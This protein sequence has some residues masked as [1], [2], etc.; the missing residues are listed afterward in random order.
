ML[1]NGPAAATAFLGIA[2]GATCAPLNPAYR[3]EEFVFYLEDLCA[4]AVVLEAGSD[5]AAREAAARLGIRVI[6]VETEPRGPAGRLVWRGTEAA[7][8]SV[9]FAQPDDVALVLHTSGTTARPKIV[10]L[11]HANLTASAGHI[12]EALGLGPEDRCL[13]VMPLFHIHGLVAAVLAT[14]AAGGTVAC[15]PGFEA[16]RFFEWLEEF[17]PTWY[18][19]VPTMHQAVLAQAERRPEAARRAG[20]RFLRSSSSALAPQVMQRLEEAFGAPVIESYGMTEAA[21]QMTS[22]P[23]PPGVRKPGSVGLPAG[24][25]VA[26]MDEAGNLLPA[27]RTGE[28][29]IRGPNVT[30]GYENNP[31]ANA[32]AFTNGWFRTGDQGYF[33]ED[34]YLFLTGRIKEIINRG[35][36]KISPREVDEVLLEHPAVAQ[37]VAFAV[38]DERLGEDVAAAVVLRP[39]ERA[40]ELEL[41][42]FAARKLVDFKVP[43]RI[44]LVDEMPKGP[45]GKIQRIGLAEKL[46]LT[47]G[48]REAERG[49]VRP[50][51]E[52]EERLC[53]MW[54]ELLDVD[55]V[56]V[57][58]DFFGLGGDSVTA[59]RLFVRIEE[60][61]GAKLPLATLFEAPTVQ[62]LAERLREG[63]LEAR[64]PALAALRRG[65]KR[66]PVFL[67]H[68]HWGNVL[69]YRELAQRLGPEQPVYALQSV[70]LD[71]SAPLETVEAMAA[72]YIE[73]IRRVQPLGP[74]I[75]GG[76]CV[77]AYIAL[78][79]AC[80]LEW[81]GKPVLFVAS[82]G[83]DGTWR[84]LES[85]VDSLRYHWANIRARKGLA[86]AGYLWERVCYRLDAALGVVAAAMETAFRKKGRAAPRWVRARRLHA[87]H[88][89]ANRRYRPGR[90]SGRVVVFQG[91][92][93]AHLDPRMF[94]SR[95]AREVEVRRVPGSA[96]GM[97]RPP[98]V[99]RLAKEFQEVLDRY[100]AS[101]RREGMQV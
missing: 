25:E 33:D 8:G 31:E 96:E 44:V 7:G 48:R 36:E 27:G 13:N 88:L 101:R 61:F 80:R 87:A 72:R 91:E 12:R 65:G 17:R 5:S 14:M 22:N 93:E 81:E 64:W 1:P 3:I 95:V 57:E 39:G 63:R 45:T 82:L 78:E 79:M 62:G 50:E 30:A 46:G 11:T 10:P 60:E 20:L 55:R 76:Y 29:V 75:L 43:R 67:V 71:G 69:F 85:A 6:E 15:T 89:R 9:E 83:A 18:T 16:R 98:A 21:H 40:T 70:G 100:A 90:F 19:A 97:F 35:G 2:A 38:P 94:W 66:T 68:G 49:Y 53:A 23:L 92:E 54:A 26:V 51:T 41:Q 32:R 37:A 84:T 52:E 99:E 86:K 77:G 73:E 47:G 58:D 28:V 34:G 56:G 24:P 42:E 74:Y 4:K 59:A